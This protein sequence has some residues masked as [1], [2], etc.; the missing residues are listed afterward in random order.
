MNDGVYVHITEREES[1][2]FPT[3]GDWDDIPELKDEPEDDAADEPS[4]PAE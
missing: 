2:D 3:A 4:Q 1:L